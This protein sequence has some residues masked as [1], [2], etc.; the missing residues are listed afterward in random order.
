MNTISDQLINTIPLAGIRILVTRYDTPKSSLSELLKNQGASVITSPM[1]MIMPPTSWLLF[2]KALQQASKIDWVVFTS[3]NGVR[4]C[5]SRLKFYG[6]SPK[7][8]FSTHKIACVGQATASTLA[9][10][11]IIPELVPEHFQSEG[12]LSAFKRYDLQHKICWLIQVEFPREFLANALEKKGA[13]IISTPVYRNVPAEN[14]Y[15]FMLK[16]L[17][18]NKLDWILFACPSAVQNFKQ[19]IPAG[20]WHSLTKTPKIACLGDVTASAVLSCGWEVNAKP[21]IQDFNHLVQKICEIHLK[22]T[23]HT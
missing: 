17:E 4:N 3:S 12:L 21:E 8:I 2:D 20:F 16:E 13:Q 10:N 11:Q 9:E 19:V 6:L 14:D 1:N 18:L 5:F 15:T 23:K 7:I 22:K